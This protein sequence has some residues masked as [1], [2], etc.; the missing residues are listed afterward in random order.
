MKAQ[1]I[2]LAAIALFIAACKNPNA[3]NTS[4]ADI[5]TTGSYI[6]FA[7]ATSWDSTWSKQNIL[8]IQTI[9]LPPSLHPT[10]GNSADR[11]TIFKYTQMCLL[12]TD[13]LNHGLRPQVVKALPTVSTD[14][15]TLEYEL[16]D[17]VTW[18]NGDPLTVEDIVFTFKANLCPYVENVDAR[19][20]LDGLKEIVPNPT[21]PKQF[22][23][24][25][26]K[27][28]MHN[29]AFVQDYV[30]MQRKLWDTKNVFANYTFAQLKNLAA[31]TDKAP[32][33]LSLWAADFNDASMGLDIAKFNGLG[34]YKV[35]EWEDGVSLT[36]VKKTNHWTAKV[37]DLNPHEQSYPEK[38]I[39]RLN[40][41]ENAQKLEFK[42]QKYDGSNI[43]ASRA[44]IELQKDPNFNKHYR[45]YMVPAYAWA[46]LGFNTKPEAGKRAP[47]FTD[48]KVRRAIALLTPVDDMIRNVRAGN[49]MRIAT[50]VSPL[51]KDE[52]NTNLKPLPYNINEAK[53]LLAEAGW[54]DTDGDGTLDKVV[55]RK[56]VSMTFELLI[57]A[58][59]VPAKDMATLAAESMGK[60]GI[61]ANL[62]QLETPKIYERTAQHQFDM[63]FGQY[64]GNSQPEDYEQLWST[65]QWANGGMN[66]PG[67]GTP[68]TDAL[69]DSIRFNLDPTKRN[70]FSKQLQQIVYDEQ[71]YVF[72][73]APKR[74]IIVHKRFGNIFA[75]NDNPNLLFNNLKLL[76][77]EPTP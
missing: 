47:L 64:G 11:E 58:G 52:V 50:M 55:N 3:N 63:F 71:P 75:V 28:Y 30:I 62:V 44:L 59:N 29:I 33:D 68:Q 5:D 57:P 21:N 8:V 69:I 61:K 2:S 15:L 16:L 1:F 24:V 26:A 40:R 10:N 27:K 31:S 36:L 53:K 38:I 45:S 56:K 66:F 20:F 39:F 17:G 43:I 54:K 7:D 12:N 25:M 49:G 73:Y 35:A 72:L 70:T 6:K 18:D 37:K 74:N 60:A 19:I 14:G 9:T 4:L 77:Q 34:A 41:D 46:F 65:K 22:K 76:Y 42:A 51:K 48:A 32:A 67:F 13:L 23:V